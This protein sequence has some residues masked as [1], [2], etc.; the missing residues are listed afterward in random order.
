MMDVALP[1][2]LKSGRNLAA[3]GGLVAAIVIPL[4][5]IGSHIAP[6]NTMRALLI[7]ETIWWGY[8][9]AILLWLHFAEK[10]PLSSIGLRRPTWKALLFGVLGGLALML[11]FAIHFGVIVPLFHLNTNTAG[12]ERAV[13]LARPFRYRFLMV[14]RAAVVEEIL[15][16]GYIIE[17][18]R[19]LTGSTALAVLVSVADFTYAH[20]SGWGFMH[21]IPVFGSAVIFALLYV[22]KRN[23]PA[24]MV[25]HFIVDGVG[26]L[27]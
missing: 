19:Q 14:L 5:P 3:L 20:L 18:V 22:W 21:L 10:L 15:F 25:A 16:R 9:A 7:R 6:G 13:I 2:P 4:L 24:N 8:A 27:L 12:A 11:V 23:L 26:F 17:K 1:T